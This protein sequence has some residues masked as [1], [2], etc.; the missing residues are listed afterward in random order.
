MTTP[1][2]EDQQ[3]ESLQFDA[4]EPAGTVA[5]AGMT[6]SLCQRAITTSYH[7]VNTAI[8]CSSCRAR[9]ERELR[10]GS[11]TGRF[12]KAA[13]YGLGGAAAG[14][15]IYYAVLAIT[16]MEI[17][18]IAILVGWLVGRGVQKGSGGRGGAAYQALAVGLTYFAIV[19]TYVP[20]IIRA[21]RD[22]QGPKQTA[23][24]AADDADDSAAVQVAV[25]SSGAAVAAVADSAGTLTATG[26]PADSSAALKTPA[27]SLGTF[28]LG[29]GALLLLAAVA[30]FL[31][32]ISNIIGLLIISFALY[33]AWKMNK[34]VPIDIT[35][36]FQ[37]GAK[38]A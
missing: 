32:G 37:V 22:N 20:F 33:Q 3:P 23:S 4:A 12:S 26:A 1:P 21:V 24:A 16:N 18:L 7:M 15:V 27:R 9:V 5:A 28:L 34:R 30:P 19:S 14:A 6:C 31:A 13:L 36:P 8:V 38:P 17:G 25:D 35:G 29:V 11:G 2:T 10:G